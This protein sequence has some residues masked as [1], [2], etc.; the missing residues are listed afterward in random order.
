MSDRDKIGISLER[1]D[2]K[3][4]HKWILRDAIGNKLANGV[5]Y[6]EGNIQVLWRHD[7]GYTGQ[8][9]CSISYALWLFQDGK[10]LELIKHKEEN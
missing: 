3:L 1:K 2:S 4:R 9:Y 6:N 10:H 8:Q 7:I 5:L